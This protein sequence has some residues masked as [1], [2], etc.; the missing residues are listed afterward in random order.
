MK[1]YLLVIL[2][3]IGCIGTALAQQN[4]SYRAGDLV[5]PVVNPDGTVTF[6]LQAPKAKKVEV[7]GDWEEAGGYGLMKLVSKKE[8]IWSY[9]TPAL[10]SE[11]YMYRFIIDGVTVIDPLNPFSRRDV[12]NIFSI[13]YVGGGYGDL[14]QVHDVPHGTVET[15]WYASAE[16]QG[17]RRLQ[18]YLPPSYLS[19]SHKSYPVLY[20]LHGSGGDE[21][22]WLDLGQ[23]NRI[24]DN[25]IAQKRIREFIVV[26]PNGTIS[27]PAAAGET[28]DNMDFRPVMTHLLPDYKNGRYEASFDEIVGFVD[29][30]YRTDA[31]RHSRAIAGLS[32]GGFHTWMIGLNHP[33]LFDYYGLFSAGLDLNI[34]Q[35]PF[36]AYSN[37]EQKQTTFKNSGYQLFWI[38]CGTDDFLYNINTEFRKQL[39]EKKIPYQY[40]ESTRG[41]LWINWRE[42]FVEFVEKLF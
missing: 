20:L 25:L 30:T 22:A 19:D 36:A 21:N 4:T 26:L 1:K 10:K 6:S 12:G 24:M 14:Y 23:I 5:S 27:K 40:R 7:I 3:A 15:V 2:L 13:F 34:G 32:M 33:Q 18:V 31:Q 42:Y 16:T 35:K 11:M 39:D 29:R 8:G 37:Y 38:A 9:T 17:Q 41:H 28:S